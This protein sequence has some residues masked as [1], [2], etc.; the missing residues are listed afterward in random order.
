MSEASREIKKKM[1]EIK[2]PK[3]NSI[4]GDKKKKISPNPKVSIFIEKK[5]I[6]ELFRGFSFLVL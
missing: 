3:R 6:M 2:T 5:E 1:E 4:C